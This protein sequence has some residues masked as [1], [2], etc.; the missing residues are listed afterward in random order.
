MTADEVRRVAL[1][2][3]AASGINRE[4]AL[5]FAKDM[6]VAVCDLDGDGARA[7]AEEIG[8]AGGEARGFAMDVADRVAVHAVVDE[9]TS[10]WGR[11]DVLVNGAGYG[12]FVDFLDMTDEQWDRMMAVNAKGTFLCTQAVVPIMRE[13]GYGRIICFSSLGALSGSV[14]HSHYAA[15]KAA[16]IGFAKALCK[17]IGPWGITINCVAPGAIDTPFLGKIPE[18]SFQKLLNNP[19]GRIGTPQDVAH[20]VRFLAAPESEYITGW[21]ISP[22]G[23]AYT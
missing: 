20:V 1:V 14:A 16:V 18:E 23:G 13:H 17:E 4:V 8:A 7:V 3:G 21:V 10:A 9:V 19:M 11:V 22:N 5:S 12:Q 2:T 6:A 15:A